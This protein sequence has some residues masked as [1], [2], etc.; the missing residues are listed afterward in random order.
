MTKHKINQY[1][2]NANIINHENNNSNNNNNNNYNNNTIDEFELV[3]LPTLAQTLINKPA[4]PLPMSMQMQL[5]MQMSMQMLQNEQYP[6]LIQERQIR[7]LY[8]YYL[9]QRN[10][11]NNNTND[12]DNA[13][14]YSSSLKATT[15]LEN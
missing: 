15:R 2:T 9:Q 12:N 1:K 11:N 3:N 10:N 5:P 14:I 8:D 6:L 13:N 4:T 7:T